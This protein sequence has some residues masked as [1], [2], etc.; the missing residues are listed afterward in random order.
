VTAPPIDTM[1][2][3]SIGCGSPLRADG[4]VVTL[5]KASAPAT[6]ARRATANPGKR[7]ARR[8]SAIEG[9]TFTW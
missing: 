5:M 9:N 3:E 6:T 4:G 1:R 7:Y 2:L 8:V